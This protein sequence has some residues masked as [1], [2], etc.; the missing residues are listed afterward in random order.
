MKFTSLDNL[1]LIKNS[2]VVFSCLHHGVSK[3]MIP[4]IIDYN[5]KIIDLSGDFRLKEASLY[6]RWYHFEHKN[7]EILAKF[8]YGIPEIFKEEISKAKYV[9]VPGCIAI[10]S[11]LALYPFAKRGLIK[12]TVYIDAKVVHQVLVKI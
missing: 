4:K 10:A 11:I 1:N 7:P 9:S 2:D 8:V 6:K 3:E 5:V 12:N